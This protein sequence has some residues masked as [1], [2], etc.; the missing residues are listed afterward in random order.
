MLLGRGQFSLVFDYW[1]DGLG[2]FNGFRLR[3]V[4][5]RLLPDSFDAAADRDRAVDHR[6]LESQVEVVT[7]DDSDLR[8]AS[9]VDLEVQQRLD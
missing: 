6:S 8:S 3:V 7:L 9:F 4:V 1:L 5:H 2:I